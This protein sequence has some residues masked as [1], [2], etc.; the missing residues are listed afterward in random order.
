MTV[1]KIK[2]EN[3]SEHPSLSS[4]CRREL[5]SAAHLAIQ[6]KRYGQAEQISVILRDLAPQWPQWL[7]I[8]G[9]MQLSLGFQSDAEKIFERCIRRFPKSTFSLRQL[10]EIAAR[11]FDWQKVIDIATGRE[12]DER[13]SALLVNA[14]DKLAGS[15]DVQGALAGLKILVDA[16]VEDV[17][18]YIRASRLAVLDGDLALNRKILSTL[19]SIKPNNPYSKLADYHDL[20]ARGQVDDA[21][22]ELRRLDQ[23]HPHNVAILSNLCEI[24]LE[25]YDVEDAAL[26]LERL[27]GKLPGRRIRELQVR[28]RACAGDWERVYQL[29]TE[30]G[31]RAT[32]RSQILEIYALIHLG[33]TSEAL[34]LCDVYEAEAEAKN[35]RGRWFSIARQVANFRNKVG[36]FSTESD[37]SYTPLNASS[38]ASAV[39][40]VI[41]M[42]WVGGQ[43]SPLEVLSIKSWLAH[44][45]PV[46]LYTYGDIENAPK[47]CELKNAEEIM[48]RSS[49]F[50]HSA[51]T[52]KSKGSFAGFADIFRWNLL[53]KVGG[54]W[55][56]CDIVCLRS[57]ELPKS[58]VAASELARTF[59]ADHMA[60]TNCF[61]GGEA[62]HPVFAAACETIKEF[63]P[64]TLGW[65]EVGTQL[66]GQ[67]VDSQNLDR[68]VLSSGAFNK[69]SPYRMISAMFAP[70]DGSFDRELGNAWGVHLYNEVWRSR[71][72]SKWGPFPRDSVIHHLF[73]TYDIKVEVEPA[74]PVRAILP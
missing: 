36:T 51:K 54:F 34:H 4:T 52:G 45:F 32:V 21:R 58:F 74:F 40:S 27:E 61:F 22:A 26:L 70:N 33:R 16:K 11:N 29:S 48:P 44:G 28:W 23:A 9:L 49:V 64:E 53:N 62:G 37:Y 19:H 69:I 8:E 13:C 35:V 65:G 67:L 43:L 68:S 20:M 38:G 14:C 3:S 60:V 63:D 18:I 6:D 15:N 10:M 72:I 50:A 25:L 5:A 17:D 30:G 42:L 47:G 66:I 39:P 1:V 46:T 71:G 2:P 57:F 31:E 55:S 41:R 7:E 24:A 59:N 56:D 73:A 12:L